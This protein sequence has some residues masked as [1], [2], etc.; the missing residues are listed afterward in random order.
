MAVQENFYL[1][2]LNYIY[3]VN[4]SERESYALQSYTAF[5]FVNLIKNKNLNDRTIIPT[6][7]QIK[8]I[9]VG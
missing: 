9:I 5:S 6:L 3:N 1:Y 4:N 7:H 2:L 8:N